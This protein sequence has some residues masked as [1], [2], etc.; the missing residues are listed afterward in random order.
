MSEPLTRVQRL[1]LRLERER[2]ARG[3]A[4]EIAER[5]SRE[6]YARQRE[7][8][9]LAAVAA[10]ANRARAIEQ[11]LDFTLEQL[12]RHLGWA[13]AQAW[14]RD[15]DADELRLAAV[16]Y[17]ADE[18]RSGPLLAASESR[19][20]V[21]GEGLPGRVLASAEPLWITDPATDPNFPRA[22]AVRAARLSTVVGFPVV[23]DDRV[24]AV[25]ECFAE[26]ELP[27]APGVLRV[28]SQVGDLLAQV[29]E[30]DRSERRLRHEACH[31]A[32]TGLPN[33]GFFQERLAHLLSLADRTELGLA[34]AILDVDHFKEVNDTLGHPQGDRLL[35]EV[36]RRLSTI[37]GESDTIARLGGD[38]FA[39]IL[40]RVRDENDAAA[41]ARRVAMALREPV[42]LEGVP[43]AVDASIGL[44]LYPRHGRDLSEL[45]R[46]ADVA[47][48]EAK[49]AHTVHRLYS[50]PADPHSPHRLGMM[51]ELR[52]ALAQERLLLHYQPQVHTVTGA[53]VA[54][55]ALLRWP[56]PTR[57]FVPPAEF[58]PVAERTGLI[59]PVTRFVLRRALAQ[60]RAWLTDGLAVTVAVNTSPLTLLDD[61]FP[62]Q[63]ARLLAE[64]G[65][66][67]QLLELEITES[68]MLEDPERTRGVLCELGAIGVSIAID[69]FGTGYSSLAQLKHLPVGQLKIDGSF[70]S[71]MTTDDRDRFIVR[72][73]I[74]L[75]HD[76]GMRIVAEGVEDQQTLVAL[77]ALG[78]DAAQGYFIHRPAPAEA[79]GDWLLERADAGGVGAGPARSIA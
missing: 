19:R 57:G 46:H 20:F 18:S 6:L 13:A 50:A 73:A 78:C 41:V 12:C 29:F 22:A 31:D 76:L 40:S 58:I 65:V 56:H 59:G 52:E 68:S 51:G 17:V 4:E 54:A 62:E 55:E 42:R 67:A 16:R 79:L 27:E 3:E 26:A 39:L 15:E 7:L 32:L 60:A 48:Y 64:A 10:A 23:V 43:V 30:R 11:A 53:V 69:D 25:L 72:G 37:L 63:V 8:T 44:A 47:M 34:V 36:G 2:R 5:S 77:G 70:V 75:G 28:V 14:L 49:R 21:S 9:L 24:A 71:A 61:R 33:R 38:E 74:R 66:P 45:M 35:I 1:E